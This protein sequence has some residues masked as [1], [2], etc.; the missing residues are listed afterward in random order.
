MRDNLR[1]NRGSLIAQAGFLPF[2]Q[3]SRRPEWAKEVCGG[4]RDFAPDHPGGLLL[5]Q[6]APSNLRAEFRSQVFQPPDRPL[7]AA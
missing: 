7:F 4:E 2:A 6:M 3:F 5:R 1:F